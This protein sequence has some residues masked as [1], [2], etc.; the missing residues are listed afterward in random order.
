MEEDGKDSLSKL[1][2]QLRFTQQHTEL[3]TPARRTRRRPTLTC[4]GL[5]IRPQP[6]QDGPTLPIIVW[7]ERTQQW[8]HPTSL[9]VPP[10]VTYTMR[11]QIRSMTDA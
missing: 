2:S 4:F 7:N 11:E 10:L 1:R 6:L 8:L 3:S 5:P 9:R